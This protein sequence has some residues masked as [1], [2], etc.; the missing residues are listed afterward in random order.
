MIREY[1]IYKAQFNIVM[2]KEF[3]FHRTSFF[4]L[5]KNAQNYYFKKV[6]VVN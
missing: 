5:N 1:E 3:K 4:Y 2:M 6:F